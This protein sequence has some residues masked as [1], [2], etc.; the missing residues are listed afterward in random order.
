ML[1]QPRSRVSVQRR[2]SLLSGYGPSIFTMKALLQRVLRASVSVEGNIVGR[3]GPGLAVFIG[4]EA[5]DDLEDAGYLSDKIAGLRIFSDPDGKFNLS[6]EDVKGD[7]LVV[8]QFTLLAQTRKGRRP[9]FTQAA[10]PE[11]A[12]K[13]VD[14]FLSCLRSTGLRVET[15]QFQK[16]MLVEIHND[17]PVTI[18]LDSRER[19]LPR[20]AAR[21]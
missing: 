20:R 19:G 7:I 8:S 11:M 15:G 6:I 3:I 13:L 10:P 17:G 4:V 16:H 21:T 14:D 2:V 18:P 9:S 12:E 5:E 1:F